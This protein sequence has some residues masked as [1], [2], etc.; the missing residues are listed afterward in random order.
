M[1]YNWPKFK[2]CRREWINLYWTSKYDVRKR[3]KA[4]WQHWATMPRLSEFGKLL[5]N[6]Q[7]L[8]RVYNLDEKKFKKTI[9]EKAWSYSKNKWVAHDT[10][11]VQFLETRLDSIL[12]RA[13][14]ASTIMQARQI[15]WHGHFLLNWNKHKVP[16]YNL[17]V[18][19][20]ISLRDK[21]KTS[22][23]YSSIPLN[24]GWFKL[25]SWLN[26]NKETLEIELLDMPRVEEIT[27]PAD[28]LKAI[29]FYARA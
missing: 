15:A 7:T 19:D 28:M 24:S 9:M 21:L 8:K 3:K 27:L 16:S 25:P 10:A 5:R 1:K 6:K 12:L 22:P 2:L 13:G 26:V 14:F 29:E 4:P 20:R 11:A 23:L 17:V 18:W